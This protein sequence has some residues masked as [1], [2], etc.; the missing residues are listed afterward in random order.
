M[1]TTSHCKRGRHYSKN[2]L[3]ACLLLVVQALER[4][5][6]WIELDLDVMLVDRHPRLRNEYGVAILLQVEL[7]ELCGLVLSQVL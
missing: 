7:S 4:V 6:D 2:K 5:E 3:I 1:Q